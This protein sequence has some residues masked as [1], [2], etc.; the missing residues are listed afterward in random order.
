M[1]ARAFNWHKWLS[2]V[3]LSS[4]FFHLDYVPLIDT[5]DSVICPTFIFFLSPWFSNLSL[6]SSLDQLIS[7]LQRGQDVCLLRG[8]TYVMNCDFLER[9]SWNTSSTKVSSL[10][11]RWSH[12]QSVSP[13]WNS[14]LHPGKREME[15]SVSSRFLERLGS[16]TAY[17]CNVLRLLGLPHQFC[18]SR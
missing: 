7:W 9:L 10:L 3:L 12:H 17:W 16:P 18:P 1:C 8:Y 6:K 14:H 2:Y 13:S 5:N 4:S 15:T 11:P